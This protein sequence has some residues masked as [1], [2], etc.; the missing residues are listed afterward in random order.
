M[1]LCF[2]YLLS[3]IEA[4]L[5]AT[6]AGAATLNSKERETERERE[7]KIL[8]KKDHFRPLLRL[9]SFENAKSV[10]SKEANLLA[11]NTFSFVNIGSVICFPMPIGTKVGLEIAKISVSANDN[12]LVL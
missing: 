4:C 1:E 8:T 11:N 12:L 10:V 7:S 3:K 5:S 2:Y 6:L 9:T